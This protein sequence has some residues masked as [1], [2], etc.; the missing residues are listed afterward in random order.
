MVMY[1]SQ[2]SQQILASQMLMMQQQQQAQ[3]LSMQMGT[4]PHLTA[5]G[6]NPGYAGIYGEQLANRSVNAGRTMMGLGGLGI[7]ALGAL[8]GLPLDPFSAAMSGGRMGL[9]AGGI[10]GGLGGAVAGAAPFLAAGAV[11][12]AYGGAFSGGMRDQAGMNSML[13]SN[14]NFAG[15][16]GAFGRGFSQNQ[17]GQIG[18][19]ITGEMRQFPFTSSQEMNQLV[20]QGSEAGMFTAV[21]DVQQFSQ[22][23]KG[24]IEGLRKIQ[25]ELGG[26]LS[27][28]MSF[29]RGAQQLGIFSQ[30]GQTAF[31]S[32]MRNTMATTGMDQQQAMGLAATGAMLSRATGGLGRQG[33]SGALRTARQLGAAMTSGAINMESLSDATGGLT[34]NEAVSAFATRALQLS[35]RFSRSGAGRY[36]LFALAN[37]EGTGLNQEM[38]DRFRA[39]DTS[40]SG[41]MGD[42]HRNV[43][44][45]GRAKA[46]NSE[47]RLRGAMMEEGGLSGQLGILRLRVGDRALE[48]GDDLAQ[49]VMQRK[50][51]VSREEATV[52]TSLMRNQANIASEELVGGKM[53]RE[54]VTKQ[55]DA[56]NRS[57]DA[58]GANLEHGLQD[59]VGL[60]KARD[61]GRNFMTKM[62]SI[63]ERT[64]NEFL[65]V[66]ASAMTTSD[67]ASLTRLSM[68][69]ATDAD[70]KRLGNMAG[71]EGPGGGGAANPFALS[72]S[73]QLLRGLG[74]H[75][76]A[77]SIGE[78]MRSRG[79]DVGGMTDMAREISTTAASLARKGI[80]T[81]S[82]RRQLDSL[83]KDEAG[84]RRQLLMS[85]LEDPENAYRG[86]RRAGISANAADA[87]A[88][89]MGFGNVGLGPDEASGMVDNDTALSRVLASAGR[90]A[91]AG[92]GMSLTSW[93]PGGGNL[94][95]GAAGAV[96][97]AAKG[98]YNEA[99]G[100]RENALRYI[101]SGGH[102]G[103]LGREAAV[104][105]RGG[106]PELAGG[107]TR[108]QLEAEAKKRGISLDEA[109]LIGKAGA[110]VDK[111]T[112]ESVVTS[113][114]FQEGLRNLSAGKLSE[115]D[116]QAELD[117]MRQGLSGLSAD[118]QRAGAI[119]I[120]QLEA[121]MR[122]NKG[123]VGKEF[124]SLMGDTRKNAEARMQYAAIGGRMQN[125]AEALMKRLPNSAINE[126]LGDV[127]S[128]Y[129]TGSES[130][131]KDA[132][133]RIG[134]SVDTLVARLSEL[135]PGSAEYSRIAEELGKS[136]EGRGLMAS[137]SQ[138]RNAVRQMSG[139]GRRGSPAQAES[140][141]GRMTGF[142]LGSMDFEL[143]G[144]TLNKRNQGSQIMRTL[145][146]GGSDA[147][148]LMNQL[149]KNM[150]DQHIEGA[151]DKVKLL[152]D[153]FADKKVSKEEAGKLYDITSKDQSIIDAQT[154]QLKAQQE[155]GNP[156]Q[157]EANDLL[158][159]I[160]DRLPPP[161]A[162]PKTGAEGNGM[163][164][165]A[166]GAKVVP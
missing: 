50:L 78:V 160:K 32:D 96:A 97:G 94:L 12:S 88:A 114:G 10:M 38:L 131:G 140:I 11:A 82:D 132:V 151:G 127:V 42:A 149:A 161:V 25:K 48:G 133:S 45:M 18:G 144:R 123:A 137:G 16:Q 23:F 148:S 136:D 37:R 75:D 93:I 26:T 76:P 124:T 146:R 122:A 2:V 5:F 166:G 107:R 138:R 59:A 112:M 98:V 69:M 102:V 116:R 29:T 109:M 92:Y 55:R 1:S 60:T 66:Q 34:G 125:T 150:Q 135:D 47:G 142:T 143:G 27:E 62:S 105:G 28:A 49:L 111:G 128:A 19:M 87:A 22:R 145:M 56:Q 77:H 165:S 154:K 159:E 3:M 162:D 4:M 21:R 53:S 86:F 152:K 100:P 103:D 110:N 52:L 44:R 54:Q 147:E 70:R 15:G 89:A 13:R 130:G 68:G 20:G 33:A 7:G 61:L 155:A 84:T 72:M 83:M 74:L 108:A 8:T 30:S 118:E 139:D 134:A 58:F 35:D 43:N 104:S 129:R 126:A 31:A 39:G 120:A 51:G 73:S 65:G 91:R 24:M 14:F 41:I 85:R 17:M 71:G 115:K 57:W 81:G 64:M 119:A 117:K 164:P 153:I 46:M 79:V 80:V 113:E 67:R 163:P 95:A 156:L 63:V 141:L 158:R 90:G 40:V 121:N 101:S 157:K 99:Y 9:A 106:V 6:A 36:S